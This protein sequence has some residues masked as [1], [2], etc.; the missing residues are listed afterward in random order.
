MLLA[1]SQHWA[2]GTS[3]R[4]GL[5]LPVF[6]GWS[7][8]V[9]TTLVSLTK[10]TELIRVSFGQLT[11]VGDRG[12]TKLLLDGSLH[13]ARK[14]GTFWR[15]IDCAFHYMCGCL[16]GRHAQRYSQGGSSDTTSGY[17][18]CSRLLCFVDDCCQC[19]VK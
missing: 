18:Y 13:A 9:L 3:A 5:L 10:T 8:C 6:H 17:W 15:D 11:Q 2:V 16:G 4:C 12:S 14:G 7:F 19:R 1:A